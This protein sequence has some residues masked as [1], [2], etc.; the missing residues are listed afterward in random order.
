MYQIAANRTKGHPGALERNQIRPKYNYKVQPGAPRC[1]I[2]QVGGPRRA[3]SSQA[4]DKLYSVPDRNMQSGAEKGNYVLWDPINRAA[5]RE[6]DE[7]CHR[8]EL[9]QAP[10]GN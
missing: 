4:C 6:V 8:C 5:N 10:V 3:K 2:V 7:N 1:V 9:L